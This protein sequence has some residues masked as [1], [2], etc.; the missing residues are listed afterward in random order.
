MIRRGAARAVKA[1]EH[2]L[3]WRIV[4]GAVTD[5]LLSHPEYLTGKGSQCA[6]QSITKLVVGQLVGHA[7]EARKRGPSGASCSDTGG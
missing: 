7:T 1:K 2:R 4:E 5:A 3:L 6:V